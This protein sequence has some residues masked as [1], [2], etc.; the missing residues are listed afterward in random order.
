[1]CLQVRQAQRTAASQVQAD[2]KD[3]MSTQ[4]RELSRRPWTLIQVQ[5]AHCDA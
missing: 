1:M 2:C 4:Q 5:M 3:R